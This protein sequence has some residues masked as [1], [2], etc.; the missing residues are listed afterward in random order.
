MTV[1]TKIRHRTEAKILRMSEPLVMSKAEWVSIGG[2]YRG[3]ISEAAKLNYFTAWKCEQ[4]KQ[5]IT[6]DE[7][8][9]AKDFAMFKGCYMEDIL[10]DGTRPCVP[11]FYRK[12]VQG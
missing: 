10:P 7:L 4:M 9:N 8:A 12:V 2:I 1:E 6:A 3:C 11:V 5:P